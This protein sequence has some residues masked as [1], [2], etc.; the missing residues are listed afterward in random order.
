VGISYKYFLYGAI[1]FTS[2]LMA[3]RRIGLFGASRGAPAEF[4]YITLYIAFLAFVV[5]QLWLIHQ[6]EQTPGEPT[7]GKALDFLL[8][9]E[10]RPSEDAL[11]SAEIYLDIGEN[12]ETVCMY[13]NPRYR[14]W[15]PSRRQAFRQSLRAALDERRGKTPGNEPANG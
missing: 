15:D 12:L 10:D 14:D 11:I 9:E 2:L 4:F 13:V 7:D 6:R 8:G 5:G 1:T 3:L